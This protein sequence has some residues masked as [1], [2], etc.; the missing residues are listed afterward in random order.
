MPLTAGLKSQVDDLFDDIDRQMTSLQDS[1]FSANGKYWQGIETPTT[2]PSDGVSKT[3][4][5]TKKPTDQFE[6]WSDFGVTIP[7]KLECSISVDVYDGP[8]GKGYC[9]IGKVNESGVLYARCKNVGPEKHR[10]QD[11]KE[12]KYGS[13]G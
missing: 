12:L 5:K 13:F 11:W 8:N 10:E 9:I 1:Y 6:D 7:A 4:D 2:V 3:T